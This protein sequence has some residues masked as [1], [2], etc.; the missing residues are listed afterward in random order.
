[1]AISAASSESRSRPKIRFSISKYDLIHNE[2]LDNFNRDKVYER[3]QIWGMCYISHRD[4]L[5]YV[6]YSSQSVVRSFHVNEKL[7]GVDVFENSSDVICM[8]YM[9][10]SDS[11]VL[12][13][14]AKH[15]VLLTRSSRNEWQEADRLKI[16]N[17]DDRFEVIYRTPI[18]YAL[19]DSRVLFG[20]SGFTLKYMELFR[21]ESGSRITFVNRI[22]LPESYSDFSVSGSGQE[23]V[24]VSYKDT[25]RVNRL[26]GDRL[27]EISR[28]QFR[29]SPGTQNV[30]LLWLADR[31]IINEYNDSTQSNVLV[32]LEVS[33][34]GLERR[35]EL[36]LDLARIELFCWC[37]V[38]NELAIYDLYFNG[39]VLYSFA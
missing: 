13:S 36:D 6:D 4:E 25:V 29:F 16:K 38:G 30:T 3:F 15:L 21:V 8:C 12:V 1:M 23:L 9:S 28:I 33:G 37:A 24:A 5:F 34:S 32:E 20:R 26:C 31:L 35:R 7:T 39:L 17:K 18:C 27:E 14:E 11:L 10:D 22:K 2:D 19:S